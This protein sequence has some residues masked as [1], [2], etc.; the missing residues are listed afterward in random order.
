MISALASIIGLVLFLILVLDLP[1]TGGVGIRP[2]AMQ[3][4]L[5]EFGHY[6]P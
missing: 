1:F 4:I 3:R 6:A 5:G 2:D